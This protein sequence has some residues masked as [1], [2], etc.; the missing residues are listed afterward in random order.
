MKHPKAADVV[1]SNNH[2]EYLLEDHLVPLNGVDLHYR[3]LG[4]G[5]V[6]FVVSPGWGLSSMYLQHALRSLASHFKLAFIDT[7]GSGLSSRPADAKLMGSVEKAHDLEAL[8]IYLGLP[9]I[10]I[11]GHSNAGAIALEYASRYPDRVN[12]LVLVDSQVLG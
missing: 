8:R 11:F 3:T 12:K 1:D 2:D 4:E 7:R 5:P 10:S 6:L 9:A